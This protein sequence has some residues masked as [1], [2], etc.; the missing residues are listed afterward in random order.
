LLG[1]GSKAYGL[2]GR[3]VYAMR[4]DEVCSFDEYWA[5]PRFACKRPRLGGSLKQIYGDNVYHRSRGG[6]WEQADSHHSLDGGAP[7]PRNVVHDTGVNRVLLS[8]RFVYYGERAALILEEFRSFGEERKDVC[9][10][11]QGHAV[12]TGQMRDDF[13]TWLEEGQRDWGVLGFPTEF[14][15]HARLP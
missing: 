14:R 9:L 8:Q 7:N 6:G 1:T 10:R 3:I 4:V 12:F 2:D 15:R 13:V 11:R 5:D